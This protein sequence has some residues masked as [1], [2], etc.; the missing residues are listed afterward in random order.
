MVEPLF[1]AI[2]VEYGGLYTESLMDVQDLGISLQGLGKLANGIVH[3]YL[4]GQVARDARLYQVR[5][6][7]GP[8]KRGS[9]LYDIIGLIVTG[10]LPLYAP[11]LCDLAETFVPRIMRGVIDLAVGRHSNTEQTIDKLI[12]LANNHDAFARQVHEGHMRDKEWLKEHIDA[13][14]QQNHAPLRELVRP[15]GTSC[16]QIKFGNERVTDAAVVDEPEAEALA[17][18]EK[19][20]VGDTRQFRGTFEGVDTTNGVCKIKIDGG[21]DVLR[22]KITDPAL[23]NVQN[24]YTHSLDTKRPIIITAKPVTKDGEIVRLFISDGRAADD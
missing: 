3:F 17:S 8:P 19:L 20:E 12:E 9:I 7:A 4:H 6:F 1:P 10:Q 11:L 2:P 22:G 16:R 5:V 24:V 13:L 14:A 18:K 21:E 15:V 23:I